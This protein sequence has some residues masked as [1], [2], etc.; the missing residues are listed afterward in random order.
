MLLLYLLNSKYTQIQIRK[1]WKA[2][3]ERQIVAFTVLLRD[4]RKPEAV[5]HNY[6]TELAHRPGIL[7]S[8]Y[9]RF[10][11]QVWAKI[12]HS[13]LLRLATVIKINKVMF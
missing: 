6:I 11:K 2:S 9:F 12:N 1:S 4:G 10:N 8:L 13:D 3:S 5:S 7:H